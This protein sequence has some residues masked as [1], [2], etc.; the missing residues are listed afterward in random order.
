M[1]SFMRN[2]AIGLIAMML[3]FAVMILMAVPQAHATEYWKQKFVRFPALAGETL[4]TGDVVYIKG[5]DG[6]AYKADANDSAKRPAVGLIGKGGS[7]GATIEIV[8]VGILAGQTAASP[9][10]RLFLSDTANTLTTTGPTN[11]QGLGW[12]MPPATTD[13]ENTDYYINVETPTS[14][15]AGY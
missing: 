8:A 5:S 9:G 1:R 15:G 13:D 11:A 12:V 4:A 6:K 7:S 14:G 10:L 3:I 2:K